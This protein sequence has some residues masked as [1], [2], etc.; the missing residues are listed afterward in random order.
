MQRGR[1]GGMVVASHPQTYENP[2]D[3]AGRRRI[4]DVLAFRSVVEPAA[5]ELVAGASLSASQRNNLLVAHEAVNSAVP[6]N[7]WP[8]D[9]R[10]HAM[11]ADLSGS[12]MLA[13][14]VAEARDST[15]EMLDRIPFLKPN[16][17][18]SGQQ[19]EEIL[20]AILRCDGGSAKKLMEVH[21]ERTASLLRGFLD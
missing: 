5:A 2:L 7:Y 4:E 6:M 3:E 11:I 15:R 16:I 13:K 18:L 9:A 19:H 8:Q 17:A 21:L 20:N 1:Y 10:L 14:A 12:T